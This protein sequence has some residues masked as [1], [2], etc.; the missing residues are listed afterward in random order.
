MVPSS[1]G[2]KV[3]AEQKP[4]VEVINSVCPSLDLYRSQ[5]NEM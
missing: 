1:P 5:H 2:A 3:S 4:S